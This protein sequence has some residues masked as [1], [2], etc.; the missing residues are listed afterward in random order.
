MR[1]IKYRCFSLVQTD[2]LGGWDL[3]FL[4][5][6]SLQVLIE[7]CLKLFVLLVKKSSFFDQ[8]LSVYQHL[9]VLSQC[10]VQR[11]PHRELH[12]VQNVGQLLPIQLLLYLFSSLA[13]LLCLHGLRLLAGSTT[14]CSLLSLLLTEFLELLKRVHYILR[15]EVKVGRVYF[16]LILLSSVSVSY[17]VVAF[18]L[19]LFALR[20]HVCNITF[21][22]VRNLFQLFPLLVK[23]L[24]LSTFLILVEA[25]DQKLN[26][27]HL[28]DT[29]S[30]PDGINLNGKLLF[31][32]F[33]LT[34]LKRLIIDEEGCFV[35]EH[36]EDV[37]NLV[38]LLF[39]VSGSACSGD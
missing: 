1:E 21:I 33:T 17:V 3:E 26:D 8:V 32:R 23:S 12:G 5:D 14:E 9:I 28:I 25:F 4:V 38:V 34:L 15:F 7:Q 24:L 2:D 10:L 35:N 37:F 39:D 27:L 16:L 18:V 29:E 6:T 19:R 20:K 31:E 22:E 30:L 36:F 11:P 13:L